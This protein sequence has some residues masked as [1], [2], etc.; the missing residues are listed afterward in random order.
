MNERIVFL[1]KQVLSGRRK[2]AIIL[3][4]LLLAVTS[5]APSHAQTVAGISPD[6]TTYLD[7]A[8]KIMHEN[9]LHRDKINWEQL[10]RDTFAQAAGAQTS[11]DTY[12]AIRFALASLGDRHSYLQL[13]PALTQAESTRKPTLANPSAMPKPPARKQSFPYPSPFRTRRVPEGGMVPTPTSPLALV[14]VPSFAS[15]NRKDLDD[16]ATSIQTVISGLVAHHPCGWIVD[17][18]G[19]GG[20]N[21]WAMMAGIGPLLGEGMV[22]ESLDHDLLK[23]P[24]FYTDGAAGQRT[25]GQDIVYAKSN[26][27]PV[28]LNGAPPVAVMIDRETGSSAEGIAIAFRGRPDTHFFGETTFGAA[29]ATFPYDLA[30]GA[31][32]YLVIGTMLDRNG[33]EYPSGISPDE[34]ILS[35]ATIS[36]NDPVVRAAS[37]WLLAQNACHE[38][39]AK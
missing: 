21:I 25:N 5:I 9:F 17:L 22:R 14:V 2:L 19:N 6:A 24:E 30:D 23:T 13:T 10:K 4:T 7:A 12:P 3:A 35:E 1:P 39:P 33:N 29:T 37:Q 31:Q 38:R 8:I 36:T 11:V 26:S 20:G 34:E 32:I 18:R 28:V 16:F 15:P 27:A